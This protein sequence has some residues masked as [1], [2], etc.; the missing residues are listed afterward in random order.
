M[1]LRNFN[2]LTRLESSWFNW[3]RLVISKSNRVPPL[4][5]R[6]LLISQLWLSCRGSRDYKPTIISLPIKSLYPNPM[7]NLCSVSLEISK[8]L[9][10]EKFHDF[11]KN[12]TILKNLHL[13]CLKI[14][15]SGTGDDPK[16]GLSPL[17][18]EITGRLRCRPVRSTSSWAGRS[19]S[20][21]RYMVTSENITSGIRFIIRK[22]S[23]SFDKLI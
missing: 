22:K 17:V 9:A 21:V 4:P 1:G 15:F 10:S 12:V 5:A 11:E 2:F 8:I 7:P 13:F 3:Q 19:P 18:D 23:I 14:L 6:Y 16:T 20:S